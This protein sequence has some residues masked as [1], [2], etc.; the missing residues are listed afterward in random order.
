MSNGRL[1]KFKDIWRARLTKSQGLSSSAKLVGLL[2]LGHTDADGYGCWANQT[3]LACEASLGTT[4]VSGAVKELVASGLITRSLARDCEDIPKRKGYILDLALPNSPSESE[5][6]PFHSPSDSDGE[7]FG[8][9]KEHR[10]KEAH[11][12]NDLNHNQISHTQN[13]GVSRSTTTSTLRDGSVGGGSTSRACEATGDLPTPSKPK[14]SKK[15]RAGGEGVAMVADATSPNTA[16]ME[17]TA[18]HRDPTEDETDRNAL[19]EAIIAALPDLNADALETAMKQ[20]WLHLKIILDAFKLDVEAASSWA[21]DKV[22]DIHERLC[23]DGKR[24]K[25]HAASKMLADD[26]EVEAARWMSGD[27]KPRFKPQSEHSDRSPNIRTN[28]SEHSD[29]GVQTFGIA[30]IYDQE[31]NHG[32]G[33]CVSDQREPVALGEVIEQLVPQ[34]SGVRRVPQAV[35]KERPDWWRAVV[36]LMEVEA[37]Q[38][39]AGLK[40]SKELQAGL[41]RVQRVLDHARVEVR[42]EGRDRVAWVSP[43]GMEPTALEHVAAHS[44]TWTSLLSWHARQLGMV[45]RVRWTLKP[46]GTTAEPVKVVVEEEPKAAQVVHGPRPASD[47]PLWWDSMEQQLG[48]WAS[49]HQ[50]MPDKAAVVASVRQ[51]I[52]VLAK[53]KRAWLDGEQFTIELESLGALRAVWP[54]LEPVVGW[55]VQ[56]YADLPRVPSVVVVE[57]A[58]S[59]LASV[60]VHP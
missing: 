30:S 4:T 19:R 17:R 38:R 43:E 52:P 51:L 53:A 44:A 15:A 3:T 32:E 48:L 50:Q 23:R 34:A 22:A 33:E 12:H 6:E 7:N 46:D 40:P 28:N 36:G 10:N 39:K 47:R 16:F 56:L 5:G 54:L 42:V 21:A 11:N 57:L 13:L 14:K 20:N 41:L 59:T 27:L 35:P 24:L 8:T 45:E 29:C 25:E 2:I 58:S 1:M 9:M 31:V 26:A 49:R 37:G 55:V 18:P 60:E